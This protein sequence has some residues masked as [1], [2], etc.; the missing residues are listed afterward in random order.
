MELAYSPVRTA[1][2]GR[3]ELLRVVYRRIDELKPDAANPRR[4]HKKQVLSAFTPPILIPL[5][6]S[7]VASQ[8]GRSIAVVRF[9]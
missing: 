5:K 7:W 3:R 1:G 2:A 8:R 6:V 9:A 4:H